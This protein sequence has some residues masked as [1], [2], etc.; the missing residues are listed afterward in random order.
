MLLVTGTTLNLQSFIGAIMTI[1]VAMANGILLVTFAETNRR[2]GATSVDAAMEGAL[3]RVR[4]ILM[5]TLAM[6]AGMVPLA[7]A[8]GQGAEQSSPWAGLSLAA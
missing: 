2:C 4:P 6:A 5:T 3:Q 8:W 7:L 1:G